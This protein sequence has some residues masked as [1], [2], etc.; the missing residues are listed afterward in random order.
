MK[1]DRFRERSAFLEELR[2]P[3]IG[4]LEEVAS[5]VT[6]DAED[7]V[8]AEGVA[9]DSFYLIDRGRVGLE[10]ASP[11]RAPFVVQTLGEGELV[12]LSWLFPPYRWAWTG[13]AVTATTAVAFNAARVRER[14]EVEP[15]LRGRIV[16]F[17][18][19]AAIRRLHATRLQLLN[20]YETR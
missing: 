6:F 3:E 15:A 20:L 14:C 9:A 18:A 5:E 13:R 2:S 19:R 16:D 1:L 17:V 11:G 7:V 8:I 12:G 4:F 10:I